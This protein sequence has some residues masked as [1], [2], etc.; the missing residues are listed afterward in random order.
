MSHLNNF[1]VKFVSKK[2][3]SYSFGQKWRFGVGKIS[4]S[5]FNVFTF[6]FVSKS[7]CVKGEFLTEFRLLE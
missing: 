4:F 2:L 5:P 7:R 3:F 1:Q 6:N